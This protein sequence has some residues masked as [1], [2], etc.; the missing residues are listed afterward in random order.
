MTKQIL[1]IIAGV[2]M[3]L[4]SACSSESLWKEE[5]LLSDG[6]IIVVDRGV[7]FAPRRFEPG[8]PATG[9]VKYWLSFTNPVSGEMVQWENP[10]KLQP[11]VLGIAGGVPYVAAIPNSAAGYIEA[12]CPNPAY[13][14]F[15]YANGWESISYQ[16]FPQSIKKRNLLPVYHEEDL[17]PVKKGYISSSEVAAAQPG[18]AKHDHELDQNWRGPQ[19]CVVPRYQGQNQ[20][21]QHQ[22]TF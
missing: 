19:D 9:V 2:F 10:G 11:M 13:F 3:V 12:G 8:Q 15:K 6:K 1:S 22:L 16:N 4:T 21:G 7:V 14:F 20:R 17:T 5:V 18:A